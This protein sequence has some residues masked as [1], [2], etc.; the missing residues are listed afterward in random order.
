MLDLVEREFKH[1]RGR[2]LVAKEFL[3]IGIKIDSKGKIYVKNIEIAPAKISKALK[4]D[5]RVVIDTAKAIAGNEKLLQIFYRLSPRAFLGDAGKELGFSVIEIRANP[6][7]KGIVAKIT[8][9][10]AD[11]NVM[12]RQIIT[13]DPELFPDP[14]LTVIAEKKI[15]AKTITELKAL[16]IIKSVLIK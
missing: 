7:E 6:K 2:Q 8:K 11:N 12:I 3:R 15:N 1:A 5:R 9:V 14:V 16:E 4:V 10:L 13:D